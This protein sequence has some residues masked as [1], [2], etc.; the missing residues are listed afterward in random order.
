[1]KSILQPRVRDFVA[2][3]L[4]HYQTN[5]AQLEAIK[6]D[7]IPS[8][9]PNYGGSEG[10]SSEAHRTT[11]DVMIQISSS[12]Y[13]RNLEQTVKAIQYVINR[14]DDIDL[15]LVELVYFKGTHT[16]GGAAMIV[17]LSQSAAY[18]HLNKVL[19]AVALEL[20]LVNEGY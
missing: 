4:E 2:W 15:R 8:P 18:N 19:V 10:H 6:R 7:L 3:Q 9:T 1:M 16:V 5:Q 14:L 20:G 11:E 17:N 13:I 12:A